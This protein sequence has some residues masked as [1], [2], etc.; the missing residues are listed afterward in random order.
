M[1]DKNN[2]L[3]PPANEPTRRAVLGGAAA[4]AATGLSRSGAAPAFAKT[5]YP[6]KPIHAIVP[7]GPGGLADV[8]M[9]IAGEELKNELG[10]PIIVENHP[11]AGGV[12]AA[13]DVIKSAPDGY[14]LIVLSNGTTIATSL[15]KNL[16]YNPQTQFVPISTVAW[17]DLVFFTNTNSPYDSVKSLLD[18]AKR[19]PGSLNI[20][21][22]NPGSTQNLAAELFKSVTGIQATIVTYRT[23]PDV[24]TAL[25]RGDINLAIESYTA[26]ASAIHGSQI[27]SIAVTGLD[28]NPGLP[29][30]PTV[31]ELGIEHYDVTGWNALYA[32][33]GTPPGVIE[34]LHAAVAKVTAL[35]SVKQRFATLGTIARSVTPSEMA[36]LFEADRKKWAAVIDRA[37]IAKH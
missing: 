15:F 1:T 29:N 10:Q 19:N 2:S 25:M 34:K 24:Q 20:G 16:T 14:M 28:R 6:A 13:S 26:F 37:G 27:R 36:A 23:S 11:G 4:F 18:K 3:A 17:F 21:T 5:N 22:V 30:V 32:P 8:T 9:R 35:P 33:A 7:F 31:R 12:A